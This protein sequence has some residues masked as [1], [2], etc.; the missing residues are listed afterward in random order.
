MA[1]R[2]LTIHR[3]V[4]IL[5][6]LSSPDIVYKCRGWQIARNRSMEKAT[7]VNTDTYVHLE[8]FIPIKFYTPA[9]LVPFT[10]ASEMN[11]RSLQ[12]GNPNKYGY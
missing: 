11:A 12:N 1:L 10:N 4:M 9:I 3:A 8:W 7:I 5:T 2:K 6:A